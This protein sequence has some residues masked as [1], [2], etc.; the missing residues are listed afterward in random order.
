MRNGT[1]PCLARLVHAAPVPSV[2]VYASEVEGRDIDV[3][4]VGD[5]L[6]CRPRLP[7]ASTRFSACPQ[8]PTRSPDR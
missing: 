2:W 5:Q 7:T 1:C 8:A 3:V 4:T 6:G